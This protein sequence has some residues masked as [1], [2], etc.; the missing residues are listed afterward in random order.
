MMSGKNIV[1]AYCRKCRERKKI[2]FERSQ[3]ENKNNK[4]GQPI[5]NQHFL[6]KTK[7]KCTIPIYVGV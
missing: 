7:I 4:N 6:F 2:A 1:V 3:N 5:Q